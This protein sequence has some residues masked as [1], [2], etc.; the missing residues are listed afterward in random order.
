MGLQCPDP[1]GVR[2][3]A[4]GEAAGGSGAA[5]GA[6]AAAHRR[7]QG[8]GPGHPHAAQRHRAAPGPLGR[9]GR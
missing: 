6:A 7:P 8:G 2:G 1:V 4:P 9:A 3:A 5:P